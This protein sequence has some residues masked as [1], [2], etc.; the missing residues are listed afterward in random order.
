MKKSSIYRRQDWRNVK[1]EG[2]QW[3]IPSLGYGGTRSVKGGRPREPRLH[4]GSY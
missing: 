2:L 1:R 3:Q 4:Q